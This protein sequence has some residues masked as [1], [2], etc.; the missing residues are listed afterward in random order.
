M[1]AILPTVGRKIYFYPNGDPA[2]QQFDAQPIDATV[3]YVWPK[4]HPDDLSTMNLFVID[5]AGITHFKTRV[6]L[7]QDGDPLPTIGEYAQWMPYQ[8]GQAA[9]KEAASASVESSAAGAAPIAATSDSSVSSESPSTAVPIPSTD[10]RKQPAAVVAPPSSTT[11]PAQSLSPVAAVPV[12]QTVEVQSPPVV[13]GTG[14]TDPTQ[15]PVSVTPAPTV[16]APSAAP[17]IKAVTAEQIVDKIKSTSY[18]FGKD[19]FPGDPEFARMT[20][21]AFVMQ[22]GFIIVGKSFCVDPT[23]FDVDMGKQYAYKE[24]FEQAAQFE[25]YLLKEQMYQ[26]TVAAQTQKPSTAQ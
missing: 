24:A 22:N 6:A 11:D 26:Q 10:P 13:A 16:V 25:G 14:T 9:K 15:P 7:I 17:T 2:I 1:T 4:A 18:A 19:V 23:N 8:V 3:V 5:H 21:C 20:F 12:P